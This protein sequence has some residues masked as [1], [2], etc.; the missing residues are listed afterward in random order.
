MFTVPKKLQYPNITK[1][2]YTD[3]S[4]HGWGIYCEGTSTGE[5]EKNWHIN[6]LE[7]KFILLSFMSIVKDHGL[8]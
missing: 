6:V 5:S 1:I 3:A 8:M 4:L 2:I 7:V